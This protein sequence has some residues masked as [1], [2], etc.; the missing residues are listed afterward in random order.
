MKMVISDDKDEK[1]STEW[2]TQDQVNA[3]KE[4]HQEARKKELEK[5]PNAPEQK[6]DNK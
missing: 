2:K 6:V 4:V 3:L 5:D 1:Y